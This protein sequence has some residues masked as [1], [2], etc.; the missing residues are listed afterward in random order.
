MANRRDHSKRSGTVSTMDTF[1]LDTTTHTK[2]SF[3]RLSSIEDLDEEI[4]EQ[5]QTCLDGRL[6]QKKRAMSCSVLNNLE[7]V[8]PPEIQSSSQQISCS[9]MSC[10]S[11]LRRSESC[12]E[13]GNG[14]VSFGQVELRLHQRTAGDNPSVSD[15]GPAFD[16][17]WEYTDGPCESVDDYESHRTTAN[18]RRSNKSSLRI[19]GRE[20]EKMLKYDNN[21]STRA[22]QTSIMSINKAKA[23]RMKTMKTMKTMKKYEKINKIGESLKKKLKRIIRRKSR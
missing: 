13:F 21:V 20:R 9:K 16:L 1:D 23:D 14:S 3:R 8:P 22:I 7:S 19:N 6:T 18:P 15:R 4:Q 2:G 10:K 12:P 17:D 11:I 5:N